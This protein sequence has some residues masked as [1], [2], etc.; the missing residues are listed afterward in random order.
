M[1]MIFSIHP[2]IIDFPTDVPGFYWFDN[3]MYS[4]SCMRLHHSW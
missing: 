3:Y 4:T 1:N 2:E